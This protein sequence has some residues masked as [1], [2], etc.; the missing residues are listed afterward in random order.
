MRLIQ[1]NKIMQ[2]IIINTEEILYC[3]SVEHFQIQKQV[4]F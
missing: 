2:I 3:I 1:T 4:V